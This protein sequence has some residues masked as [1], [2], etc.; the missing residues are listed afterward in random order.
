MMTNA[1][2]RGLPRGCHRASLQGDPRVKPADDGKNEGKPLWKTLQARSEIV[3]V[4]R[5]EDDR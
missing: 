2:I 4:H 5:K 1:D 3:A